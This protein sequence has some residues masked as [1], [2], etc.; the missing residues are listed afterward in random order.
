MLD[1]EPYSAHSPEIPLPRFDML[2]L[3]F[4]FQIVTK[5]L[6]FFN[7]RYLYHL[8]FQFKGVRIIHVD[9]GD[10]GIKRTCL[11]SDSNSR[12]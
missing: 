4:T 8:Y 2:N 9:Y 3:S 1:V 10:N 11:G 6:S 7:I 5:S 12:C